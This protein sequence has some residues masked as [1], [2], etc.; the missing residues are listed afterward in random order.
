MQPVV[1]IDDPVGKIVGKRRPASTL[2]SSPHEAE[3][4]RQWAATGFSFPN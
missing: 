2:T 4:N 3:A 1:N